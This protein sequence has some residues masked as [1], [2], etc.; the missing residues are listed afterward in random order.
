MTRERSR[1][2]GLLVAI[3]ALLALAISASS[4][5]WAGS[6]VS[7]SQDSSK[8]F[9]VKIHADWCG[10][11]TRLNGPLEALHQ[12]VGDGARIVVLDVTDRKAVAASTAE[13]DRLGI[14]GFFDQ[15]KGR[16]GTVGVLDGSTRETVAVLKGEMDVAVYEKAIATA[17][18]GSSS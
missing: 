2:R 18:A 17:S 13:A 15:Y 10:T 1:S 9:V 5:V 7:A 3:G 16:T 6:E 11:C 4:P 14:R 12:Q 8:P